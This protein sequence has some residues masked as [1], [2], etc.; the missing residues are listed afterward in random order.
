MCQNALMRTTVDLPDD[1]FRQ[2]MARA[3]S[4]QRDIED[5]VADGLKLVLQ[6]AGTLPRKRDSAGA[7]ARQFVGVAR[8]APGETTDDARIDRYRKKYGV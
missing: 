2:A 4:Q 8:L 3:V 5:L 7:W 1:L 6:S